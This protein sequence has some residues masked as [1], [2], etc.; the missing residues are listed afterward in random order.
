MKRL[1]SIIIMLTCICMGTSAAYYAKVKDYTDFITAVSAHHDAE[2]ELIGDIDLSSYGKTIDITFTGKINGLEITE[3]GDSIIHM[4]GNSD[5]KSMGPI[6]TSLNNATISNIIVE[7]YRCETDDDNMGVLARTA[8]GAII[9]NVVLS[10]ISIFADDNNAG[11]AVGQATS[12]MFKNVKCINCDVTVDGHNAGG[13]VGESYT[14]HYIHC[15]NN[16]MSWVFADGTWGYNLGNAGGIVGHSLSDDFYDCLNLATIGAS[17]DGVGGIVGVAEDATDKTHTSFTMCMNSGKIVQT[18]NEEEFKTKVGEIQKIIKEYYD[19]QDTQTIIYRWTMGLGVGALAGTAIAVLIVANPVTLTLAAV[20]W[21]AFLVAQIVEA[22]IFLPDGH[23]ELG[24]IC[25]NANSCDFSN[26]TNFGDCYCRDYYAGGIAGYSEFCTFYEC[27]NRG[28]VNGYDEVG[29]IA[30]HTQGG[31]I[32]N[33]LNTG[34]VYGQCDD[35]KYG[36]LLGYAPNDN[37]KM[38]NNYYLANKYGNT[39]EGQTGVTE[40]QLKSGQVVWWLNNG[41]GAWEQNLGVEDAPVVNYLNSKKTYITRDVSGHYGT[42][43]APFDIESNDE[44]KYYT[45]SSTDGDDSQVGFK[46]VET[47]PAGT[48][49]LFKTATPGTYTMTPAFASKTFNYAT[50]DVNVY[51]WTMCGVMDDTFQS[52]VFTDPDQLSCL[53]YVSEGKIMS[54]TKQ[55]TIK[56][57]RAYLEG[58]LRSDA[59]SVKSFNFVLIDDDNEATSIQFVETNEGTTIISDKD[60]IYNLNGQRLTAPQKGINIIDGK[61]VLVK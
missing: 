58:P 30:G 3:N 44:I 36:P 59:A 47:L 22:I 61:K 12:C 4:I 43:V 10:R 1:F 27:Y 57:F 55:L 14:S 49:A 34:K 21:T 51:P 13:L 38:T 45:L 31:Y 28:E 33:C 11:A 25:G 39:K 9:E 40:A 32:Q 42:I 53:Y 56:P 24:G 50:S 15:M 35:Y 17:D 37:T 60:G 5:K 16:A 52:C 26:C 18:K 2:I 29:G 20:A 6:F 54:A 7:N 19:Q 8:T 23:D 48:P 46:A 41:A